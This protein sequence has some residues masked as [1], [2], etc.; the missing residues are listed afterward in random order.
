MKIEYIKQFVAA[1]ELNSFLEAS[2]LEFVEY[3]TFVKHM[4]VMEKELGYPLFSR[5]NHEMHLTEKGEQ[6]YKTFKKIAMEYDEICLRLQTDN[7]PDE[8]VSTLN[9]AMHFADN[10]PVLNNICTEFMASHPHISI[11]LKFTDDHD[12]LKK[13]TDCKYDLVIEMY[14]AANINDDTGYYKLTDL[15]VPVIY[16][17]DRSPDTVPTCLEDLRLEKLI[18]PD[19]S[20]HQGLASYINDLC[21]RGF[22]VP[23]NIS[24]SKDFY[25]VVDAVGASDSIAFV[26]APS[27]QLLPKSVKYTVIKELPKLP[28]LILW[29]AKAKNRLIARFVIFLTEKAD[30]FQSSRL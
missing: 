29:N 20:V 15:D 21:D 10:I 4:K 5:G 18:V 7:D 19:L 17:A 24:V 11:D 30:R 3:S 16:S 9:I 26:P 2:K 6:C 8:I 22:I 14:N 27:L 1:A 23:E 13:L 25:D 28:L 12:F